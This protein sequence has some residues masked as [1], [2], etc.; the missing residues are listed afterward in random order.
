MARLAL[1]ASLVISIFILAGCNSTDTGKTQAT[2]A[3]PAIDV[4]K[5]GEID[6]VKQL[7]DGRQTYRQG[8]ETMIKY[9]TKAG[10]NMKLTWAQKELAALNAVPQYKYIAETPAGTGEAGAAPRPTVDVAKASEADLAEQ[11]AAS[12][13]AYRQTV[14]AMIKYY[15][16]TGDSMKL[17]WAK[18]ELNL[19]NA[20]P[21]YK[22]IVEAT[23]P[24]PNLK[25]AK[26]ITDADTL[27]DEAVKLEESA[28]FLFIK[29]EGQMRQALDKY[30]QL[31]NKYP[32]S[33]K[34]DDAA[35]RA[36]GIY[37]RLG[38]YKLAL[39]YYQRTYQWNPETSSPARFKAAFI[40][41][42]QFHQRDEALKLY[43]DALQRITTSNEHR[44]WKELAEQRV[45]ELSGEAKPRQ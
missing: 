7:A 25:A 19:L 12:R 43:Q 27:Y 20:I 24:G 44:Q 38:D 22:Y 34:I 1:I 17:N 15:T 2:V 5:A 10:N 6:L 26:T 42:R 29:N 3:G 33:D 37:E 8:V 28:Q 40:F 36:A 41:D 16:K 18:S 30:S 11:L 35:F 13:L 21:Q 9:Y 45:K 4:P 14:E 32:T 23:V 31:I 39:L